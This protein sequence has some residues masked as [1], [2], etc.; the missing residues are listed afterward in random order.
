M[1][2]NLY[3]QL[4]VKTMSN[5][6]LDIGQTLALQCPGMKVNKMSN[7]PD[8]LHEEAAV[9]SRAIE[10]LIRKL[11]KFLIGRISLVRLQEL[12]RYVFVEEIENKLR[13]ENPNKNIPL[14]QLALL[15]GLDTRTLTKI[16][17]SKG[18]RRPFYQEATFLRD[19]APGA[20]ILDI[21][22]SQKPYMDE[23]SGEPQIL[24]VSGEEPSFESLFEEFG[25]SRGITFRS[26]L[27]RLAESGAVELDSE[28]NQVKLVSKSYLPSASQDKLGAIELGFAAIGNMVDTVTRNISAL[29]SGEE[30][31]Y[32]RGAWTYRLN[33]KN[34][35]ALRA[36][37][38]GLLEKTDTTAREIIEMHEDPYVRSG[39]LTAGISLFYFEES[40]Q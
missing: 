10:N 19:F 20:S 27:Q 2:I 38:R 5:N 15:S 14:T 32:Q 9:L 4:S 12:I 31:L 16:R 1:C 36:E 37:L 23:V 3:F 17:N 25:K 11:I 26:L 22:S 40:T 34:K 8:S 39:Q 7:A 29:D 33:E 13:V 28:R 21:W 30:R 18:Y 35:S 6:W 24:S